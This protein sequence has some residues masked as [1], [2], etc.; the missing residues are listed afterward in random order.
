MLRI[1]RVLSSYKYDL[2]EFQ[3]L[4]FYQC[5]GLKSLL[6]LSWLIFLHFCK[7]LYQNKLIFFLHS[8]FY[9]GC[10]NLYQTH[11]SINYYSSLLRSYHS[12]AIITEVRYQIYSAVSE[13]I[14]HPVNLCYSF[15]HPLFSLSPT[16]S[17]DD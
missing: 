12:I 14:F 3:I 2:Y 13:L 16:E 1:W 8:F 5:L 10:F 17:H 6:H 9:T 7:R 15:K 11:R 4:Q